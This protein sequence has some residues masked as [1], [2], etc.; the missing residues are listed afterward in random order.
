MSEALEPRCRPIEYAHATTIRAHPKPAARALHQRR[1][2]VVREGSVI[3]TVGEKRGD[4]PRL[5]VERLPSAG[6]RLELDLLCSASKAHATT[7]ALT[8]P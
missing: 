6:G 1:D 3:G 2:G 4:P 5:S 8:N 7:I